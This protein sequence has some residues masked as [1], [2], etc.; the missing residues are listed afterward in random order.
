MF[1]SWRKSVF[2]KWSF[3]AFVYLKK[4]ARLG[5]SNEKRLNCIAVRYYFSLELIEAES[6]KSVKQDKCI[7]LE[8]VIKDLITSTDY[9]FKTIDKI[10]IIKTILEFLFNPFLCENERYSHIWEHE[11]NYLFFIHDLMVSC[12]SPE[13]GKLLSSHC[14]IIFTFTLYLLLYEQFFTVIHPWY[15]FYQIIETFFLNVQG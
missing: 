8:S 3:K 7:V 6:F 13:G 12:L 15:L 5:T 10:C 4:T 2:V 1:V 14:F 9:F 11:V